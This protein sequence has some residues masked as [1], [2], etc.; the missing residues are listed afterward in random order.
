MKSKHMSN[1]RRNLIWQ[2][3]FVFRWYVRYADPINHH[4]PSLLM[5]ETPNIYAFTNR[6]T[7]YGK[8]MDE[9][10]AYVKRQ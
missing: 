10:D 5:S 2:M 4:L 1:D 3:I 6:A 7:D 8:R 9:I